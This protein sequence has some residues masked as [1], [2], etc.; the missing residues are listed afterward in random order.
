MLVYVDAERVV[1]TRDALA[2]LRG[3]MEAV[4]RAA[5]G[6]ERHSAL[7]AAFIEA[8]ELAQGLADAAFEARGFDERSGAGDAALGLLLGLAALVGRSWRSG[9]V[10]Q[11]AVP[12][13][14]LDTLA[15]A[16]LPETIRTKQAEGYAFYA[17]C[18]EAFFEAASR[19]DG[20][21]WRVIGIR[22]IG[23][24]LAAM[25][26]AALGDPAPITVRPVGHPFQRELAVSPELAAEVAAEREARFAVVDEGPGLSGS[27]FGAVID[28]LE[29]QGIARERIHAFPS[30]RGDLGPQASLGH[31]ERWADLPR[32]VADFEDLLL[33]PAHGAQRIEA[34][35]ADI[36]GAPLAPL[37]DLSGGAWRHRVYGDESAWPASNIQQ[38]RRKYLLRTEGGS[39]LLKFVGLGPAPP[40][41]LER[42]QALH[43]AG[44]T[45]EVRAYRHG[46]LAERWIEEAQPLD[47]VNVD[48][49]AL[50]DTLGRYLAFR[51]RHF[52]APQGRGASLAE[53][54][55]MARYNT[56]QRLGPE[57]ARRL[58]HWNAVVPA[59]E[60]KVRR[61]DT[62]NRMHRHEWLALPDGRILKTD[63]LD[64]SAAHDLVGCQDIAWDVAGAAVEWGLTEDETAGLADRVQRETGQAVDA[65]LIAFYRPCYLAFQLGAATMAAQAL[66]G[67]EAEAARLKRAADRYAELLGDAVQPTPSS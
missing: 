9:L 33:R 61:A 22:S 20:G 16:E 19:L 34:W 58:D 36:L 47:R 23:T 66:A 14:P 55:A 17:L 7:V 24:G 51:S 52:S 27:S 12:K 1:A 57:I 63:A 15:G 60:A 40:R 65:G 26:A 2:S 54:V 31:R 30:H 5:P 45:S 44:F 53:L 18:P 62:D 21:P 28:W 41:K 67:C 35:F 46:F 49:T 39:W 29:G 43:G 11:D 6:I 42:A 13:G 56:E 50:L 32:H 8:S 25:V 3:V 4:S 48:R 37:A 10:D 64:H 38:E 59:L